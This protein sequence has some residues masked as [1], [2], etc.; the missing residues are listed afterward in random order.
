MTL[1]PSSYDHL[2]D[3]QQGS[4][5]PAFNDGR[6]SSPISKITVFIRLFLY[7]SLTLICLPLQIMLRLI[8]LRQVWEGFCCW[9]HGRVLSIFG[10]IVEERG[11]KCAHSP[12]LFVAN[13]N[14]YFDIEILGAKVRGSFVAMHQVATWPLFGLLAKLQNTV[15]IDRRASSIAQQ[16]QQITERF[17]R[18]QNLII[19]PEGS[20][21]TSTHTLP[22]RSSLFAVTGH[23]VGG[24][25]V[26][27]Q[28][29]SITFAR[30][31]GLPLG[32]GMRAYYG[33]YGNSPLGPHIVQAAGLGRLTVVVH[34][35]TP[36]T[37]SDFSGN[38]KALS[39][40]CESAIKQGM[41]QA[42]SGKPE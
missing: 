5:E 18:N 34:W 13:H 31:D 16:Q 35:H 6:R 36:K 19:F 28:P 33:W 37:I 15:F 30:L 38:R 27:V 14:S 11:Q 8:A 21:Y 9:Y 2:T 20:S 25:A 1:D 17:D 22:F 23:R 39:A 3:G 41:A 10:V 26:S 42:R 24:K 32:R 12:V 29:V 40:Y 4:Q 7:L